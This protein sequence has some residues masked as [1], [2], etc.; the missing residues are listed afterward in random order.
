MRGFLIVHSP[1]RREIA[2]PPPDFPNQNVEGKTSLSAKITRLVTK[3]PFWE[4]V[5]DNARYRA[6]FKDR[7]SGA[8]ASAKRIYLYHSNR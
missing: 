7:T 8:L 5:T 6:A 3:T 2:L 1:S 4:V